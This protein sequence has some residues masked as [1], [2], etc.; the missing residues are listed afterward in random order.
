MS[1]SGG[2]TFTGFF[3]TIY[4]AGTNRLRYFYADAAADASSQ[5]VTWDTGADS[6]TGFCIIGIEI[7]PGAGESLTFGSAPYRQGDNTGNQ[8]SGNTPTEVLASACL[9]GNVILSFVA[10]ETNPAGLT[11]PTGWTIPTGANIGYDTPTT[12]AILAYKAGG[13]TSD[14]ITWGSTSSDFGIIA[15]EISVTATSAVTPRLALLGVG[16]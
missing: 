10:N 9:T 2:A 1:G 14:T 8:T 15:V 4:N 16:V 7:V 13:F 5:T 12:G 6:T 3:Q 11:E